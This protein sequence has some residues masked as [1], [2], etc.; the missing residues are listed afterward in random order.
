MKDESLPVKYAG[1]QIKAG[2]Q[3][4]VKPSNIQY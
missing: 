3:V 2:N 1:R 4:D